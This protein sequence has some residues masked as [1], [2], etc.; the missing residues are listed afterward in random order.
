MP[1]TPHTAK[2]GDIFLLLVPTGK[3]LEYLRQKSKKLHQR[4]GGQL[5]D[6][7]HITVER[8]SPGEG[9]FPKECVQKIQKNLQGIQPFQL[10]TDS[11]IQFFAPYWQSPVL[12][13]RVENSAQWKNFRNH[14]ENTLREA[15]CPSHF[16]RR[17]HA[18]CTILK[19][20]KKI[21]LPENASKV[22]QPLFT[23]R[24]I[25][26]SQLQLNQAFEILEKI[27]IGK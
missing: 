21:P 14:L 5:V 11:L 19:L 13:W 25:R 12:R 23:I 20:E 22:A 3:D 18:S 16:T 7:I 9:Q 6:P 15:G 10:R 1:N 17:R 26:I 27:E 8:F 4:Y 2:P 24:E